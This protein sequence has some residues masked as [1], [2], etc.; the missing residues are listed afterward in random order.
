[1]RLVNG[2]DIMAYAKRYHRVLPAFNTTNLEMTYAIANGLMEA[3]LPGYI[4]ISSNNLRLSDAKIIAAIAQDAVADSETPIA[5]HL[6][7]GKSFADV[8][9]CVDAG[10][11]SIMIDMSH[12]PFEENV[13]ECRRAADYCHFY[14]I[15]VEAE[16][17]ALQGKEEDVVNESEC[18]TD[19]D[20]VPEFVEQTGCDMLAVSVGNV[21]GLCLN[22]QIDIPLLAR[23][24]EVSRVPLV[25]HGGSGIPKEVIWKAKQYGLIKINYGSDLRKEYIRTFGEAYEANHNEHDV[26]HLSVDSVKNVADKAREL[27][28]MINE[29]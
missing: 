25:L 21:H 28:T 4:Q 29:H 14:G 7:H 9:A 2:F 5:L 15:P 17:G 12:L 16:L 20:L 23:I 6:D 3:D 1:M 22:P 27:V 10:F 13:K 18:K 24:N 8:K 19:P 26:I 11:T